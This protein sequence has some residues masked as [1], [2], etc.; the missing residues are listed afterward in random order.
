MS[1]GFIGEKIKSAIDFKRSEAGRLLDEAEDIEAAW[2]EWDV[3]FLQQS[4]V[5]TKRERG[6]LESEW[7][8]QEQ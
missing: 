6:L 5:I 7:E 8:A 4:G 1:Y 3:D 2:K